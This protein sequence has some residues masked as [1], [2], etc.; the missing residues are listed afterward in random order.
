MGEKIRRTRSIR[1]DVGSSGGLIRVSKNSL[2]ENI[3][4]TF[5]WVGGR[6]TKKGKTRFTRHKRDLILQGWD[7]KGHVEGHK[8]KGGTLKNI[9]G[10]DGDDR[11][12]KECCTASPR[13]EPQNKVS[14]GLRGRLRLGYKRS[15]GRG[16]DRNNVMGAESN[17]T[18]CSLKTKKYR[19]KFAGGWKRS[20]SPS[21]GDRPS[22]SD[23]TFRDTI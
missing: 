22:T 5:S 3:E 23:C 19:E 6:T 18:S 7:Q 2:E 8:R 1:T 17:C 21:G 10:P 9:V 11:G 12:S 14:S 16:P 4:N 13:G 15:T 20:T